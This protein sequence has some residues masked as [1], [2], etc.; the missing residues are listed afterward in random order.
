MTENKEQL[1]N[2]MEAIESKVEKQVLNIMNP[3]N[4]VYIKKNDKPIPTNI[5]KIFSEEET[6]KS[7]DKLTNI[8]KG[9]CDDFFQKMGRHPTYSEMRS[10]MG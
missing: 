1:K 2:V 7:M 10:M 9:G 4:T 5:G 8:M 3:G 6:Q